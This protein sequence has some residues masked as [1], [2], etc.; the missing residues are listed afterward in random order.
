MCLATRYGTPCRLG[1][2]RW[3]RTVGQVVDVVERRHVDVAGLSQPEE[4]LGAAAGAAL[5]LERPG[6]VGD[7]EDGLLA[8]A[9]HGG[10]DEVGDR[11][12]VERAVAADQHDRVVVGAVLG[13][14]R[15]AGQVERVEHVGV[16]QLGREADAEDV[17]RADRPVGVDG[18][19]RHVVLAHQRLEVWPHRVGA[20]GQD[21]GLLVEH[22]VQ[23]HDA[24]VGQA[25]LVGIGI[26]QAPADVGAVPVLDGGVELA[27]DILDRLLDSRQQRL[28]AGEQ[29]LDRHG[30][31]TSGTGKGSEA[32]LRCR[33]GLAA[34][35]ARTTRPPPSVLPR[36]PTPRRRQRR[37]RPI[38]PPIPS[39]AALSTRLGLPPGPVDS[40]AINAKRLDHDDSAAIDPVAGGCESALATCATM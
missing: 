36:P 11:L 20:L 10:V 2:T 37:Y 13:V 32:S 7:V 39:I 40:G 26:H 22:L 23:D 24:L 27:A 4:Q 31:T 6:D 34:P 29:G 8:V 14:Q 30:G 5:G 1:A 16:A 3:M 9:E 28:K 12:R 19:L 17:E 38:C 21:V 25:D 18:E 15:D 33:L 35:S